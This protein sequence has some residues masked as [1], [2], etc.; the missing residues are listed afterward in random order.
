MRSE[1]VHILILKPRTFSELAEAAGT[2][3]DG[4]SSPAQ[5]YASIRAVAVEQPG[6]SPILFALREGIIFEYSPAFPHLSRLD[7]QVA[8]DKLEAALRKRHSQLAAVT[9]RAPPPLTA[10]HPSF[11]GCRRLALYPPLVLL[12]RELCLHLLKRSRESSR[13]GTVDASHC[14]DKCVFLLAIAVQV[15]REDQKAMASI[16]NLLTTE[17]DAF[18]EALCWSPPAASGQPGLS[19]ISALRT[20]AGGAGTA[21]GAE[22][23]A[24]AAASLSFSCSS[25]LLWLLEE[26]AALSPR[27][28]NELHVSSGD[29]HD[30][31][32]EEKKRMRRRRAKEAAMNQMAMQRA[33][34]ANAFAS[35]L[36]SELV[37]EGGDVPVR[38]LVLA[39]RKPTC[40]SPTGLTLPQARTE[41][42]EVQSPGAVRELNA[43]LD[44]LTCIICHESNDEPIGHIG[45]AQASAVLGRPVAKVHGHPIHVQFCGHAVHL[46][47]FAAHWQTTKHRAESGMHYDGR[48]AVD[49]TLSEFICPLCKRGSNV[50][51]PRLRL[52]SAMKVCLPLRS[53]AHT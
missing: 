13:P 8:Q 4:A 46:Q 5:L 26:A 33:K 48:S 28:A 30:V 44:S 22:L 29:W 47:C 49:I 15:I 43:E 21:A 17:V 12:V 23:Q 9:A 45:F 16:P 37:D 39:F 1:L 35:E 27:C 41:P 53:T 3:E 10:V 14:F 20:L 52:S 32:D 40:A 50:L 18:W 36:E 2:A 24:T 34:F 19:L 42:R 7:H 31:E 25:Q 11:Y 38:P 51:V 6:S